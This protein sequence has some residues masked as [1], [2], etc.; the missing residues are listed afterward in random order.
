MRLEVAADMGRLYGFASADAE[1]N[2]KIG[3]ETGIKAH[4]LWLEHADADWDI[5]VGRQIIIWGKADGVQ[6]TDII[7]PPDY[8]ESITRDLDEIRQP[9]EA[10]KLR[11][12]GKSVNLELI[13]IPVFREAKM[14]E[15]DNPWAITTA[16]PPGVRIDEDDTWKPGISL[17]NSEFAVKASAYFSGLDIAASAFYNWDD[18]P[19]RHRAVSRISGL[20]DI[21]FHP[22]YHR[23]AVFGLEFSRPWSDFVFRGEAAYYVGRSAK[24]ARWIAIRCPGIPSN[25]CWDLIGHRAMTG[26]FPPRS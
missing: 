14:P 15:G 2:W 4:E 5:R 3:S 10:A 24:Q 22:K 6:V 26:R 18:M 9:V 8:T 11:L 1:K 25:G 20:P 7:C 12:L 23:M 16:A 19:A 13:W 21:R 17:Q